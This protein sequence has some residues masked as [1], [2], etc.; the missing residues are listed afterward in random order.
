MTGRNKPQK[1]RRKATPQQAD[2]PQQTKRYPEAQQ[3]N[4]P[5]ATNQSVQ[6]SQ[7]Q[8][9]PAQPDDSGASTSS[10]ASVLVRGAKDQP[11]A[12]KVIKAEIDESKTLKHV[13]KSN[14]DSQM[15]DFIKK[16]SKP[17]QP[18]GNK[19]LP[20]TPAEAHPPAVVQELLETDDDVA[21]NL[22]KLFKAS[23]SYKNV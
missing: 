3:T 8:P 11:Q 12:K 1:G 21:D 23:K 18:T 5:G 20:K 13:F 7:S 6:S 15:K 10:N 16:A 9:V 19:M 14:P 4:S 22:G 2:Q 17:S